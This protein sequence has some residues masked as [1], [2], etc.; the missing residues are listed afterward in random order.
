MLDFKDI[1]LKDREWVNELL[2]YNDYMA[3]EYCFTSLFIWA[4]IF[5][6]KIARYN[7]LLA[8]KSTYNGRAGYIFPAGKGTDEEIASIIG[9]YRE[10]AR[11]CG[12]KAE[13]VSVIP[14]TRE[15]LERACPGSFGFEPVRDSFDYIYRTEDLINLKGKKY[16]PKRN[17]IARFREHEWQYEPI[18][19]ANL[20]ECIRMNDEWCRIN[21]CA[22]NM[23][24][25][26]EACAVRKALANY[27]KLGL[28]GALLRTDG[29][30][31]AYTVGETLNSNTFIVHIEKAFSDIRGAYPMIN[32][33]FLAH[34][35]GSLTY[36]NREDDAG[37]EGLRNAK[38][39]YVP[40]F[41]LEKYRVDL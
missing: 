35:A 11:R 19:E 9:M 24:M 10:D 26:S 38:L 14:Q 37:D 31:V 6:T 27:M 17:H 12:L 16:Q 2:S 32:R 20:Q 3:T 21:G 22:G 39:S 28:K 15:I 1:G 25:K 29:K 41:L 30:V 8:I 33:E 13:M 5:N 23:S 40:A 18:V 34:E 7:D 36:V 4:D